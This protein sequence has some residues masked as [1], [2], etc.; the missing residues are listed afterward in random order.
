VRVETE[1]FRFGKSTTLLVAQAQRDL[2]SSQISEVIT[3]VNYLKAFVELYLL[4]GSL[5]ERRGISLPGR[6]PVELVFEK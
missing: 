4:E 3:I 1:K 5:L 6:E 2:L